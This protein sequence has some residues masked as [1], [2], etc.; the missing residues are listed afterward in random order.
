M[1]TNKSEFC[2]NEG[3]NTCEVICKRCS[4]LILREK[5]AVFADKQIDV[6]LTEVTGDSQ[7]ETLNEQ[8]CVENMYQ[9]ENMGFSNTV[10]DCKFLVCAEC[11]YGPLG[12]HFIK[13]NKSY[14][15]WQRV[16]NKCN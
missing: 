10:N 2:D 8:W 12:V 5:Q 16:I 11:E 9:F 13:L 4:C 14:L 3:M 7:S 6:P 1:S 15:C